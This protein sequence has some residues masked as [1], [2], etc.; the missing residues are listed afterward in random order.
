MARMGVIMAVRD[1]AP[2]AGEAVE[3]VLAQEFTDWEL[4]VV[5]DGSTDGTGEIL[6][7]YG[8]PRI[9]VIRT[10][11]IGR[12]GA[13]NLALEVLETPWVAVLD[14]DDRMR[15]DRLGKQAAYLEAHPG[16][17]VLATPVTLVDRE[18]REVGRLDPP[19]THEEILRRLEVENCFPHPSCAL[20]TRALKDLGGYREA[21]PYAQDYDLW[22]RMAEEGARFAVLGEPLTFYR[23]H[24]SS[25]SEGRRE[26]QAAYAALARACRRAR[27]GGLPEP[28]PA[29]EKD[30]FLL[31]GRDW[32]FHLALARWH[33]REGRWGKGLDH[34]VR[35]FLHGGWRA[36]RAWRF[37][38]LAL[39]PPAARRT[40]RGMAQK[41]KKEFPAVGLSRLGEGPGEDFH[42]QEKDDRDPL[43]GV[44]GP[45]APAAVVR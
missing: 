11:G 23:V 30:L 42:E 7:R 19:S 31:A 34:L 45:D 35:A 4:V 43:P 9:R 2:F 26:I 29:S 36:S 38:P 22:L 3:S 17:S 32:S 16:V 14:G 40:W 1:G 44:P 33:S 6:A 21:F 28:R 24:E 13:R 20:K 15:P 10:P 25:A 12:P 27:L 18:G 39:L 8:D 37:L 5:D 41:R